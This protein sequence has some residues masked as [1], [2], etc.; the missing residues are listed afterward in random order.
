MPRTGRSSNKFPDNLAM[1]DDL[2]RRC[3]W[4]LLKSI[5]KHAKLGDFLKMVELRRKL[6]PGD[7]DQKQFWKMLEKI[8]RETLE[9]D[10]VKR[11]TPKKRASKRQPTA[12]AK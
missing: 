5:E 6:A 2:I 8:R 1:L 7:S 10:E 12:E 4:E 11:P 9:Q 3:Y